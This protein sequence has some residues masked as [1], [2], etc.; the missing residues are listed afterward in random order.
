MAVL[1]RDI[2]IDLGSSNIRV[3]V[4]GKGIVLDE[5]SVIAINKVTSEVLALGEK[6]KEMIGK[7]PDNIMA[8]RPIQNGVI[9]D[10]EAAKLLIENA[11]EKSC[12]KVIFQ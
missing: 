5:P 8:V 12:R 11:I 10:Y 6:A 3:F 7:T 9:S 4:R 2:G 1:S